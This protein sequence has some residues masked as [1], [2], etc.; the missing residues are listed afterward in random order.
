MSKNDINPAT[1]MNKNVT[2]YVATTLAV[3]KSMKK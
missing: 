2:L 1:T 3:I